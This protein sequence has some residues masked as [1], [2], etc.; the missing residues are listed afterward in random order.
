MNQDGRLQK[1]IFSDETQIAVGKNKEISIWRM[2][3]E[4]YLPDCLG[5]Y[6][7]F[8]RMNSVAVMFWGYVCSCGVGTLTPV[9]GYVNSNEHIYILNKY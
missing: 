5:Q 7:D 3:K 9:D 6:I 4:K 8:E 1:I 2:D